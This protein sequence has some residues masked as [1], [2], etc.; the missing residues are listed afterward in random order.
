MINIIWKDFK[1][2]KWQPLKG[3][4]PWDFNGACP[5]R[6]PVGAIIFSHGPA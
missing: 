2:E 1:E 4:D 3:R 5:Y 6:L